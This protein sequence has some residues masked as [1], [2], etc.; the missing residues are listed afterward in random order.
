MW[1]RSRWRSQ[2]RQRLPESPPR[3]PRWRSRFSP[4]V[5]R[6][7]PLHRLPDLRH[8]ALRDRARLLLAV[9]QGVDHPLGMGLELLPPLTE[10]SELIGEHLREIF[11]VGH[12]A[13]LSRPAEL[14]DPGRL[15]RVEGAMIREH[16]ASV[17]I[18]WIGRA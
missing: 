6:S 9:L 16:D 12:A 17:R 10:G 2:A 11:L 5:R 18:S 14:V 7:W 15:V 13:Q 4:P 8:R 3:P 1:W